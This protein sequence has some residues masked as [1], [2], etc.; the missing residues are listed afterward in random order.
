MNGFTND[1]FDLFE[2][3]DCCTSRDE[4]DL[5]KFV[6]TVKCF[7]IEKR[8]FGIFGDM[9]NLHSILHQKMYCENHSGSRVGVAALSS[10]NSFSRP[11]IQNS[12]TFKSQ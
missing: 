2:K 7:G 12:I 4:F 8:L 1:N 9:F 6:H 3:L 5:N 10:L 11:R